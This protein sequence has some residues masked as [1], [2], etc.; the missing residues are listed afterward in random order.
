MLRLH[1]SAPVPVFDISDP[2]FS[3]NSGRIPPLVRD[4]ALLQTIDGAGPDEKFADYLA[5]GSIE[6]QDLGRIVSGGLMKLAFAADSNQIL[7][8]VT[9]TTSREVSAEEVDVLLD[10]TYSQL[11]DGVGETYQQR[12]ARDHKPRLW[13]AFEDIFRE[14]LSVSAVAG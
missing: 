1:V 8:Y 9:Y 14:T 3:W 11:L 6:E 7:V 12:F 2:E 5:D 10:F 13:I 4:S